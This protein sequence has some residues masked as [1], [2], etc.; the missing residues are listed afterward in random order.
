MLQGLF[1]SIGLTQRANLKTKGSH[2]VV[3]EGKRF[4]ASAPNG[5]VRPSVNRKA[6]VSSQED[7][8]AQG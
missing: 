5:P 1:I 6:R 4:L 3:V 7:A 8:E 2:V